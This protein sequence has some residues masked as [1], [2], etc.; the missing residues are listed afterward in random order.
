[1]FD[2]KIQKTVKP[3]REMEEREGKRKKQKPSNEKLDHFAS[4]MF[5]EKLRKHLADRNTRV[6]ARFS[7]QRK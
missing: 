1:M 6:E 4:L 2:R 5:I 3:E 7:K